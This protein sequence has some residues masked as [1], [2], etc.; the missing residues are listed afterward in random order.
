MLQTMVR[1][2]KTQRQERLSTMRPPKRGPRV[3]P[4]RGPRRYQPKIPARSSGGNM[5]LIVPPPLAMPMPGRLLATVGAESLGSR[6]GF[7]RTS[8][9][10]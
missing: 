4:M 6:L 10:A 1:I 2:Q 7:W 5:S 8:K 3:G 9:K